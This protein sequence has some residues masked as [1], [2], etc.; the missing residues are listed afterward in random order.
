MN[1]F[2]IALCQM[3]VGLDKTQNVKKAVKFIRKAGEKADLVVLP[4]MF[5]CPYQT[6]QFPSYAE[7]A[8]ESPTLKA[9]SR[10]AR[11]TEVYL[12]AGS[13][14]ERD[15][16]HIYNTSF[17][18]NPTGEL[19]G[20]HRK[21]HLFDIDVPGQIQFKESETLTPGDQV[22]VVDTDFG[23]LGVAICYDIRFPELARLMTLQGAQ[24]LVFPGA[25][26]LTTGPAHWEILSRTRALDNQVYLAT[27]SPARDEKASYVAYGHSL[28]A[29][30]WGEV[31][32]QA[33]IGEEIL[34]ASIKASRVDEIRQELPLLKNRRRDLYTLDL[35]K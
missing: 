8:D 2:Q 26:N 28:V 30:P 32:F 11:D 7:G 23:K 17:I 19:I 29:D 14:P 10:A 24:L 15:Q 33:G 9:V 27:C 13:I 16:D 6:D 34:Y 21:L 31:I 5:N 25:F 3:K 4:E 20:R 22:T 1:D 35:K 12:V 18:Y